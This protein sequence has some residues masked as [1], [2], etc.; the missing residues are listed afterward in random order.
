[1]KYECSFCGAV[2]FVDRVLKICMRCG[3]SFT[4]GKQYEY[5]KIIG[6]RKRRKK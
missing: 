5:S 1:M 6:D 2:H 3:K 4:S